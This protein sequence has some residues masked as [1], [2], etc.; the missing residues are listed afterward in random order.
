MLEK[1][2]ERR[3]GV[4]RSCGPVRL[5]QKHG[6]WRCSN[7]VRKQRGSKGNKRSRHHGLTADERAEMITQAGVCAICSTPVNEKRGRIDHCHTTNEL[8][9]VL[10]NAC[11]VGLGC[12]KDS[13]ALL[14]SAIRYLD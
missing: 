2:P 9:G 13:V 11:N 5:T 12:F 4:C 6:S 8:R 14:R 1:D 7:A 3:V 10:C